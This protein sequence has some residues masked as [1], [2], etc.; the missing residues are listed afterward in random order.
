VASLLVGQPATA[1]A[2]WKI[3]QLPRLPQA[4]GPAAAG[5]GP[6]ALAAAATN[7]KTAMFWARS[8]M[9]DQFINHVPIW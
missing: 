9:Y 7:V 6:V 8:F 3:P 5:A 4:A 1:L 2:Q